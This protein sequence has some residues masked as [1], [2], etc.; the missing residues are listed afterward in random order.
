MQCRGPP[1]EGEGLGGW[2]L[3]SGG[4]PKLFLQRPSPGAALSSKPTSLCGRGGP[5]TSLDLGCGGS[6]AGRGCSQ[7]PG[8]RLLCAQ[9][10]GLA[11]RVT[12]AARR[13]GFVINRSFNCSGAGGGEKKKKEAK[14]CWTWVAPVAE[15]RGTVFARSLEQLT[16][17]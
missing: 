12:A 17:T 2:G 10:L 13:P 11:Q 3:L 1:W 14:I 16:R 6:R 8:V 4:S 7:P 9:S 5:L 15:R